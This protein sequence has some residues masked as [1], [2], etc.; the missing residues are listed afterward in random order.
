MDPPDS[1]PPLNSAQKKKRRRRSKSSRG[2]R[3]GTKERPADYADCYYK[4]RMFLESRVAL[5]AEATANNTEPP[6]LT[7]TE[8]EI[9]DMF[10][11]D[12]SKSNHA[13]AKIN[14]M[15]ALDPAFLESGCYA[16]SGG[17]GIGAGCNV[18]EPCHTFNRED[19]EMTA[20]R[21]WPELVLGGMI[22]E[23]KEFFEAWSHPE[24][25]Q[26]PI[27]LLENQRKP[28]GDSQ[29]RYRRP[30]PLY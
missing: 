19:P 20:L 16:P 28:V 23:F 24:I 11:K 26:V 4:L 27:D 8:D 17:P 14:P 21:L 2:R 29:I 15:D 12:R 22:K 1:L 9:R 30:R 3:R 13:A 18:G 10:G 5:Q 25:I 7:P 6:N